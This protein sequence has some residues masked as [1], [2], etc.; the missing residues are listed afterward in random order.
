MRQIVYALSNMGI[1][2]KDGPRLRRTKSILTMTAVLNACVC[3]AWGIAYGVIG[4]YRA[5]AVP[6]GYILL[7]TASLI[8]YAWTHNFE[9]F[10]VRQSL[11]ILLMPLLIHVSLGGFIPSSGVLFLAFVVPFVQH[12]KQSTPWFV[13][14]VLMVAL[15]G[16]FEGWLPPA[17]VP[18]PPVFVTTFFVINMVVAS[19]I[20]YAGV[21]Y[22][23]YQ[24]RQEHALQQRLHEQLTERSDQLTATLRYLEERTT[25][26]EHASRHKSAFLAN[27]SHELRTPLNA[28]IG[29]SE[30]L[31]EEAEEIGA[32]RFVADLRK[33]QSSGKHLLGLID[34]VLDL[35]KVEAG[36]MELHPETFS[37]AGLVREFADLVRPLALKNHNRFEIRC[38]EAIN[39]AM[40]E[41]MD[42]AMG[43]MR[44]D[45]TRV[46]QAVFNLLS[47][48]C[49]FTENGTICLEVSRDS[50]E[51]EDWISF[52]VSDT[53][54]GMTEE[55][56][57][58]LFQEFSQAEPST[59]GKY[60]GTGLGLA[61]S[62]KLCRMMGGDIQVE[63]QPGKGSAFTI[64]LPAALAHA[65]TEHRG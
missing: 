30:M 56:L 49:K 14:Y 45:A 40:D 52:R 43:E 46:R 24:L 15:A 13:V 57:G 51:G 16:V 12:V 65:R 3:P 41:A 36:R 54:I 53:G 5:A 8:R 29:Y 2:P 9:N 25:Q 19:A 28:I 11:L 27:M 38:N 10:R 37:V 44:S 21:R 34:D 48:A 26:L 20:T 47:N 1:R 62:R 7:T 35:S 55:Q 50:G 64:R 17:P 22:F 42:E 61:L 23:T 58:K 32:P 31:E 33:I 4:D 63:S 60:G 18:P 59:S 6:F 39:E